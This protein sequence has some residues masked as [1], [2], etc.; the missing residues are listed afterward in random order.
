MERRE[1]TANCPIDIRLDIS[2][3]LILLL[4]RLPQGES[5]GGRTLKA[6]LGK[7]GW[8]DRFYKSNLSY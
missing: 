2:K 1:R 8:G 5:Q 6:P 4:W 7:G 3:L